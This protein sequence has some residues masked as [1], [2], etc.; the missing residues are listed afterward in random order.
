MQ[1]QLELLDSKLKQDM[2]YIVRMYYYVPLAS[3]VIVDVPD[4]YAAIL[5][6]RNELP[7]VR[8]ES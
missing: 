7:V 5:S 4:E 2:S 3:L 6:D 1:W 8:T